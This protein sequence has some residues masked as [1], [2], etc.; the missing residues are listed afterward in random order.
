MKIKNKRGDIPITILVI[1]IL[2][3]CTLTIF[4]FYTSSSKVKSGF[5]SVGIVNRAVIEMQKI[6]LYSELGFSETEIESIFDIKPEAD[7]K[8]RYISFV[9]GGIS[10]NHFLR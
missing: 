2:A 5:D 8:R 4:S 7:G 9:R 6:S 10:V 3:I 1:G